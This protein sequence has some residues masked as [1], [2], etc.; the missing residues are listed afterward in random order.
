MST[1]QLHHPHLNAQW[2]RRTVQD[3]STVAENCGP[4][5]TTQPC[6]GGP[7]ASL[8]CCGTQGPLLLTRMAAPLNSEAPPF[9]LLESIFLSCSTV[10]WLRKPELES[11]LAEA[12]PSP[13]GQAGGGGVLVFITLIRLEKR[14][15]SHLSLRRKGVEMLVPCHSGIQ[16]R[17]IVG[18]QEINGKQ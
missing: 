11:A 13:K 3:I 9:C 7:A 6:L 17:D 15:K 16:K 8:R 4:A 10:I 2:P 5:H 18:Q 14:Q 1:S 12:F